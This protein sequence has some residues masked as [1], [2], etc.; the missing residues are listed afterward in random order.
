MITPL[1]GATYYIRQHDMGIVPVWMNKILIKLSA[2][3][4]LVTLL[5]SM[6]LVSRIQWLKDRQDKFDNLVFKINE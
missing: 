1:M 5:I 3:T 2:S 4:I 6:L